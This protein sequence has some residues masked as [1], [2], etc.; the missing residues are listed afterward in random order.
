MLL[1]CEGQLL[2]LAKTLIPLEIE[3]MLFAIGKMECQKERNEFQKSC[4]FTDHWT[5]DDWYRDFIL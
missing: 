2:S 4:K 5:S 1:N 3:G